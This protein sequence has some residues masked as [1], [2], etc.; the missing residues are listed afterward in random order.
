[1]LLAVIA[2]GATLACAALG[3]A[4]AARS[5]ERTWSEQRASLGN[6]IAEFRILFDNAQAPDPRFIRM[7]EQSARLQGLKFETD[8][9]PNARE[10]QPVLDAQGRIAGFPWDKTY[11]VT[12]AVNRLMP[13][14]ALRSACSAATSSS[15]ASRGS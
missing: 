7:V 14:I 1:M 11:P 3:Y 6:A 4:L 15:L 2:I 12:R 10:P 13:I 5:D 9:S 8:L